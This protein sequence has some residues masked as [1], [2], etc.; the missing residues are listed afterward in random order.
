MVVAPFPSSPS[1]LS[2]QHS[3]VPLESNAQAYSGPPFELLTPM[4]VTPDSPATAT[5]VV[6]Q[7]DPPHELG[8]LDPF[9]S[10]P[11]TL[12]PQQSTVPAD[13]S[14]QVSYAP[15]AIAVT[16]ESPDT[17]AGVVAFVPVPFPISP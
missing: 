14:A 11:R 16:P 9:P 1:G 5:G 17:A 3:T 7:G 12:L 15:A 2:P 4:A 8:P 10:S 6:E 13:S